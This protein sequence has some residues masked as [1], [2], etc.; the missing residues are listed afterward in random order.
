MHNHDNDKQSSWMMWAMMICCALPIF[1]LIFGLG[2][3]ALG[4]QTW[5]VIGGVAVMIIV[6]FFMMRSHKHI[7]EKQ[8]MADKE[9]K[10]KDHKTHSGKG[11]CH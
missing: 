4:V 2:G 6:H 8:K 1:I 9:E 5:V 3:K 7:D 10:D 11:C